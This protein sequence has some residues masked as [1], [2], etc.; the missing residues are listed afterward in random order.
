[1]VKVANSSILSIGVSMI[2]ILGAIPAAAQT[3]IQD[4][5]ADIVVTA[6][7]RAEPIQKV[8]IQITALSSQQIQDA[9]VKSTADAVAQVAGVNFDRGYS[10]RSAF[11]TMRG[12]T[13]INNADPPIAFVVDGVPQP[14]QETISVNL[15]DVDRIEILKGPQG[16]LYGRN[17]VGGAINVVSKQPSNSFE[18]SINGSYANGNAIDASAGVSG[19]IIKD[20]VLFDLSGSYK[21]ADGLIENDFRH[22]KV[23]FI[24]HDYSIRGK[25]II[26]PVDGLKIDLRAQY[27]NFRGSSTAYTAVFSKNPNEYRNPTFNMPGFAYGHSTDLTAKIDY[28]MG[29]ATI[30]SITGHTNFTQNV[31]A[32]VDMSNPVESPGGFLGLGFQAAQGQDLKLKTTSQEIRIVSASDQSLRW[33]AGAYYLHTDRAVLNRLV[34]DFNSDPAQIEDPSHLLAATDV[35][36]N[37]DAYSV[38][39]QLDYDLASTLTLTGG[40]RYDLDQRRQVDEVAHDTR[41][42]KFDRLQPKVTLTWKPQGGLLLYGTFGTGFRSGGF[43]P[44]ATSVPVFKA[45]TLTNYEVGFKSQ[46]FGRKLTLNGAAYW[47]NVKN[48]QYFYLDASSASQINDNIDRVRI[49][50]LELEAIARLQKGL[51][52]NVGIAFTDSNIRK[53][54]FPSD[55]GGKAPRTVPFAI[56]GALQYRRHLSGDVEGFARI[57]WRHYGNKY[58]NADN[59]AVQDPYDLVTVRAGVEFGGFGIYGFVKNVLGSKYYSEYF[60]GKYIGLPHDAGYLGE[61][62]VY[63][64]EAKFKF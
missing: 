14:N 19:P 1:M 41:S 11:I 17:A 34:L 43:N 39:G 3:D 60:E 10:Y 38:F 63:G 45:E 18:G 31:R 46:F 8:P 59:V 47:M 6:Q 62:R 51:D 50:G 30:T 32:D 5:T 22:D 12:L 16:A 64:I 28:D 53:S 15:F 56:T 58:W 61:P 29:F 13:Q 37:N 9:A 57:E 33:L 49:R 52:L 7:Q 44:I 27:G 20:A 36:G 4:E 23:D 2:G 55:E 42:A 24:D 25:L 21:K 26:T 40:L 35:T 54:T 48:Y